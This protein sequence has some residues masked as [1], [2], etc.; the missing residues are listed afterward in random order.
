[1]EEQVIPKE[2]CISKICPLQYTGL[3][4]F[5]E[6]QVNQRKITAA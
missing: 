6:T 4:A 5:Q 2:Q 1:M 3:P